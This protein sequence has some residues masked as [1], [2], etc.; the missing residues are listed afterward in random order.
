MWPTYRMSSRGNRALAVLKHANAFMATY[1]ALLRQTS[2]EKGLLEFFRRNQDIIQHAMDQIGLEYNRKAKDIRNVIVRTAHAEKLM[3]GVEEAFSQ[4]DSI[5]RLRRM[6]GKELQELTGYSVPVSHRI[7]NQSGGQLALPKLIMLIF[8]PIMYLL[9]ILSARE[10]FITGESRV[11]VGRIVGG[12]IGDIVWHMPV[13]GHVAAAG[14]AVGNA[15]SGWWADPSGLPSALSEIV[16]A[17]PSKS[18]SKDYTTVTKDLRGISGLSSIAS[19]RLNKF[20]NTYSEQRRNPSTGHLEYIWPFEG[21]TKNEWSAKAKAAEEKRLVLQTALRKELEELQRY[22]MSIPP[23]LPP[24]TTVTGTPMPRPSYNALANKYSSLK[25]PKEREA[26]ISRLEK[27]LGASEMES[28]KAEVQSYLVRNAPIVGLPLDLPL[29]GDAL[30]KLKPEFI[31]FMADVEHLQA[32]NMAAKEVKM[33]ETRRDAILRNV[34]AIPQ[35]SYGPKYSKT[36]HEY[37]KYNLDLMIYRRISDNLG[38]EMSVLES[39][40]L[41]DELHANIFS[42]D[43]LTAAV[44]DQAKRRGVTL[45]IEQQGKFNSII[46][47]L[48]V[49]SLQPRNSEIAADVILDLLASPKIEYISRADLLKL[50]ERLKRVRGERLIAAMIE[51]ITLSLGGTA[52]VSLV[53]YLVNRSLADTGVHVTVAAPQ[54]YVGDAPRYAPLENRG[55]SRRRSESRSHSRSH[56]SESRSRSRSHR[57]ES[58]YRLENREPEIRVNPAVAA[59]LRAFQDAMAAAARGGQAAAAP[60]IQMML[61]S[62]QPPQEY[63]PAALPYDP[64]APG[65]VAYD[66]DVGY[67]LAEYVPSQLR[68][69]GGSRKLKRSQK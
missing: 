43:Q 8:L 11:N 44:Y 48:Q 18:L 9:A 19:A 12:M 31:A 56:R 3:K 21:R 16:E 57:S 27:E 34:D 20:T 37:V 62:S 4:P 29:I 68:R 38:M 17:M 30:E 55:S 52:M 6:L 51:L 28:T 15:V 1:N 22:H 13:V 2:T 50:T 42:F 26:E 58:R 40:R 41:A 35:T 59:Q 66:P 36:I 60:L 33:L 45:T 5:D 65:M 63:D 53:S 10:V 24:G 47:A 67:Q 61:P 49:S 54:Q 32:L 64:A 7:S 25:G 39:K 23:P 46:N 69:R 14:K